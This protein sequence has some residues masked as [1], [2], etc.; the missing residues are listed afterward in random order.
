MV[1]PGKSFE[2]SHRSDQ[3]AEQ[4]E[5]QKQETLEIAR[6]TQEN[7]NQLLKD[8][9]QPGRTSPI[10]G[11]RDQARFG[12]DQKQHPHDQPATFGAEKGDRTQ[13]DRLSP[14]EQAE[15]QRIYHPDDGVG[16]AFGQDQLAPDEM[17]RYLN[18]LSAP[19]HLKLIGGKSKIMIRA[20][21][22]H[23]GSDADNQ[24]LSERRA[25]HVKDQLIQRGVDPARIE[26]IALGSQ[27]A[28]LAGSEHQDNHQDRWVAINL[29]ERER[30]DRQSERPGIR[31][32]PPQYTTD[33][34]YDRDQANNEFRKL[35]HQGKMGL[36]PL[37][38]RGMGIGYT[39]EAF[40]QIGDASRY[41]NDMESAKDVHEKLWGVKPMRG[42]LFD[43]EKPS[44]QDRIK[45]W[46]REGG[47]DVNRMFDEYTIHWL[48]KGAL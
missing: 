25:A 48:R 36:K 41:R 15:R 27:G 2:E 23:P 14:T 20:Y 35:Y 46:L 39:V 16:F 18:Q 7:L 30:G 10:Y 11:N 26:T 21:A 37:W 42:F 22:S 34:E 4:V 32:I 9:F 1:G 33:Y 13:I 44:E 8:Q 24:S 6:K 28:D 31:E 29:E 17:D 5:R 19:E 38:G 3:Q 40:R 45:G 12:T 43:I 47:Y